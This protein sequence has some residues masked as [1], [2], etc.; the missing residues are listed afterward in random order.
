LSLGRLDEL[1]VQIVPLVLGDGVRLFGEA[2]TPRV[3]FE[4]T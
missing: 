3:K 2:P 1:I 4:R